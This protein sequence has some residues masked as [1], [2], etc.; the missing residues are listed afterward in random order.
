MPYHPPTYLK[1]FLFFY[2]LSYFPLHDFPCKKLVTTDLCSLACQPPT[3]YDP[4][5]QKINFCRPMK[6]RLFVEARGQPNNQCEQRSAG[7]GRRTSISISFSQSRESMNPIHGKSPIHF[8]DSWS[9]SDSWIADSWPDSWWI[10]DSPWTIHMNR[11]LWLRTLRN[12]P[13]PTR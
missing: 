1:L 9:C 4:T 10:T 12:V 13:E 8:T 3:A 5:D 2:K 11:K 7:H 6:N